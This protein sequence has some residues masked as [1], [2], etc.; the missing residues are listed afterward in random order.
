MRGERI[1][2]GRALRPASAVTELNDLDPIT[3]NRR[4]RHFTASYVPSVATLPVLHS[5]STAPFPPYKPLP[6]LYSVLLL[7]ISIIVRAKRNRKLQGLLKGRTGSFGTK[8]EDRTSP[9]LAPLDSIATGSY[10]QS[11]S[12]PCR[13]FPASSL[14]SPRLLITSPSLPKLFPIT[15]VKPRHQ[16]ATLSLPGHSSHSDLAFPYPVLV[17]PPPC[18][19]HKLRDVDHLLLLPPYPNHILHRPPRPIAQ[20]V[21]RTLPSFR[22]QDTSHHL[23]HQQ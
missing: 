20:S 2:K 23:A 1:R 3:E 10:S 15:S 12:A 19:I 16:T 22:F 7:D 11:P 8:S 13:A 21:K 5:N 6:S 18:I 14:F 9:H 4:F 17:I